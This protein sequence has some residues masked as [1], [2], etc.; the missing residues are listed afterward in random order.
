[1][2][3]FLLH[4]SCFCTELWSEAHY[5][6]RGFFPCASMG[7]RSS[8]VRR[9]FS[10]VHLSVFCPTCFPPDSIMGIKC[11]SCLIMGIY[12]STSKPSIS[13][14]TL[15][16]MGL[17]SSCV[18]LISLLPGLCAWGWKGARK[19]LIEAELKKHA[20]PFKSKYTSAIQKTKNDKKEGTWR[21]KLR[22]L[23]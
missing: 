23:W 6:S 7:F 5:N 19:L 13:T 15:A 11:N 2:Q 10:S 17:G 3:L 21:E 18:Y 4:S 20:E 9:I 1:M 22:S 14:C 8:W 12:T 16:T